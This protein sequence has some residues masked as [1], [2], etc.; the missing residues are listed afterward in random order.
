MRKHFRGALLL[1]LGVAASAGGL[2][3]CERAVAK[4]ETSAEAD[5]A[6]K[7]YVA[8]GKKDEFYALLSGG[9]NGQMSVYGSRPAGC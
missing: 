7:V 1:S 8:P 9:F 3:G 5:A 4:G 6:P 2:A